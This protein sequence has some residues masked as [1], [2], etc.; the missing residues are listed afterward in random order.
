MANCVD[1]KQGDRFGC[2]SC[3][4]E[5]SVSKACTCG[6]GQEEACSVPLQCCG[7]D[8]VKK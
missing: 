7:R 5:L 1:M 8:M 6:S 3:G 2:K 4:F